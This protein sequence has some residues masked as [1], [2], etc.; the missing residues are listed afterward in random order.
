MSEFKFACPVC[1]QHITADSNA[2]GTKIECPTCFRKIVVPQA[3]AA[4]DPKLILS[5]AHADKPRPPQTTAAPQL[6]PIKASAGQ[7]TVPTMIVLLALICAGGALLYAFRGKIFNTPA[8]PTAGGTNA[9]TVADTSGSVRV[10]LSPAF[11]RSSGVVADGSPF[12]AGLDGTAASYSGNLLGPVVTWNNTT[13]NL[14]PTNALDVVSGTGQTISLPAGKFSALRV[15]ATGVQG[16][17]IS[18]TFTVTYSDGATSTFTQS[19]SDWFTP[20]NYSGEA[21][22]VTMAYRDMGDSTRDNRPFHL[23]GYSF[24]LDPAKTVSSVRLPNNANVEV[25]AITLVP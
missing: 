19:M 6:G 13:F 24:G 14:G 11:N 7:K 17:Q 9:T 15:L 8:G 1:G 21:T 18:Q 20:Q 22:V 25:L 12:G 3:P 16:N 10:N 5:A 4:A 23:Y 2:T